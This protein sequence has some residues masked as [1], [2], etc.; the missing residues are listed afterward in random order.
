MRS[1]YVV[2]V[3]DHIQTLHSTFLHNWYTFK[4]HSCFWKCP[5]SV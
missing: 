1:I 4:T 2:L 3:V 5:K